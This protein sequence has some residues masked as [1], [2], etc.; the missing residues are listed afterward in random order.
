MSLLVEHPGACTT[1]QDLGR[2]GHRGVGVPIGGA[3]DLDAHG[4][5]NALVGNPPS[6]ASLEMTLLG[7]SYLALD[8]TA[9]GLA[10]A[11]MAASV[12]GRPLTIPSSTTLRAGERLR[13]GGA[14]SGART[15]LAV[16]WGVFGPTVLGS[17]SREVALRGGDRLDARR[18]STST[19]RP[20]VVALAYPRA[21]TLR[22]VDGLDAAP[23]GWDRGPWRVDPTSG[24][25]GVRLEGTP[26]E[27][28]TDAERLSVPTAVGAIQVAGGRPIVLGPACGTLGGYPVVGFVVSADV[29]LLAQAGP[30][31]E[32]TLRRVGWDE[33][34]GADR[35]SREA[36]RRVAL[37]VG[38]AA[39]G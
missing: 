9:I 4:L 18:S 34:R 10:G 21:I 38:A 36:R 16:A 39:R 17:R 31:V 30:G 37:V 23:D 29:S 22:Y 11:P 24:R 6:A 12:E 20:A 2:P 3:F 33:A 8:D 7:G 32:V 28:T 27:M 14:S 13:L 26:I 5:A 15:Y 35:A 1:V 25:M 19:R